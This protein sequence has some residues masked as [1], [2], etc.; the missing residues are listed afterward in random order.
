MDI[1]T[2][3]AWIITAVILFFI[4]VGTVGVKYNYEQLEKENKELKE[5]LKKREKE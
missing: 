4:I 1:L 5:K 2:F 3:I